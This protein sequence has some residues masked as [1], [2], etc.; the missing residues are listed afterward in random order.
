MTELILPEFHEIANIFPLIQGKEFDDLVTDIE[1]NGVHQPIVMYEGKVLD[2][3]NRS[4]ACY[5]IGLVPDSFEYDGGDPVGYVLSLNLHRRHLNESQRAMVG[6]NIATL[7][8]GRPSNTANLRNKTQAQVAGDLNVSERSV[9]TAKKVQREGA[10]ELVAEVQQGNISV[11]AAAELSSLPEEAQQEAVEKIQ[12]GESAPKVIKRYVHVGQNSGENEWYTP[13][14]FIEAADAVMGGI[15]LD[16]ASSAI[17]NETVGAETYY[18]KDD[19]GLTKE[20]RGRVWMN[21]PYAQPLMSRFA[22]KLCEEVMSLRVTEA[23]VLVNNATETTWFQRLAG[24]SAA[25]CFVDKRV[26]FLDPEGN[27][28]APLQG[29][30]VLYFGDN[31]DGTGGFADMFGDAGVVVERVGRVV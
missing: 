30:A 19:D 14:E 29:Q 11:S 12:A 6:A 27:K 3:R 31:V 9:N 1:E 2:G 28:G 23:I 5:E 24:L 22:D 26:R 10:P 16:P 8:V 7:E 18:T 17:A 13:I 15:D 4:R 21:P 25:I 20:W